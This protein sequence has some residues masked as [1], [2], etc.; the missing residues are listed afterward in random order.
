MNIKFLIFP[1]LV[2][3]LC[4]IK[5][6]QRGSCR[7]K[8]F[9]CSKVACEKQ[10]VFKIPLKN[11]YIKQIKDGLKTVEGRI[12]TGIFKIV[13]PGDIIQFF[14]RTGM[15]TVGVNAIYEYKTFAEMLRAE[16]LSQILPDI[17]DVNQAIRLYRSF[18]GYQR[19]ELRCGVVA[20]HLSLYSERR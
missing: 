10:R 16:K 2:L 15:I 3:N 18:P 9:E 8:E 20:V 14:S 19:K 12:N 7:D 17:R 4:I 13:R 5:P 1:L 11:K 6:M